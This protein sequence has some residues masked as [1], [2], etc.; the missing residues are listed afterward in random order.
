MEPDWI[1]PMQEE[2]VEFERNK[3]WKLVLKPK[4]GH[5]IVGARWVYKNKL[6]NSGFE[7]QEFPNHCYKLEKAVYSLKQAPRA[8]YETISE[9]LVTSGYKRGVIDPTFFR[10]ANGNHLMLIQ[11][12]VDDIIFGSI[13]QGMVNDFA[14]L[15]TSKFQM[16]MNRE[17]NF[18]LGIQFKQVPQ[19]IFTHQEKYTSE[20]LKKFSMDNCSSA[21]VPMAFGYKISADPT[22]E[23]VNQ[24]AY[25]G[26]IG[27]LMYLTASRPGIVFPTGLCARYQADPKVSHLTAVK[28]IIRYLQG[29]KELGLWYPARNDFSLQAFT[30]ADH[31]GC[32][33]DRKSTSGGCQ[34]LGGRLVNWS[35]RKQN[36]VSLSTVEVKHV[37]EASCCS[38]VLWIKTQLMD[39]GYR[40]LWVTN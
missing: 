17:I 22:G 19:G 10:R 21:K 30:D 34:F 36:C 26:M 2:L 16:I 11:I 12:Y 31:A 8:W 38:Q 35:S 20:L 9:F 15:M 25:H 5:T 18:F 37:A 23:S 32:R 40:M 33:L 3:V 14:K 29:S 6:D 27:S 7:S 39:Y 24:K 28:Q 4:K 1:T 13:D